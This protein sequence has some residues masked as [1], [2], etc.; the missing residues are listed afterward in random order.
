MGSLF[1]RIL[2]WLIFA[3]F[4]YDTINEFNKLFSLNLNPYFAIIP[5]ALFFIFQEFILKTRTAD[6]QFSSTSNP[7][8]PESHRLIIAVSWMLV[9]FMILAIAAVW[10]GVIYK[11]IIGSY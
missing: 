3:F 2:L 10:A 9:L 5:T 1:A 6:K 4:I 7:Q 8:A 11:S